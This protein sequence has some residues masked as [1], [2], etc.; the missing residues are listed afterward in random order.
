MEVQSGVQQP[1]PRPLASPQSGA[2]QQDELD[3]RQ[4]D[5]S[6]RSSTDNLSKDAQPATQNNDRNMSIMLLRQE[7]EPLSVNQP[8]RLL[9]ASEQRRD[10]GRINT[11]IYENIHL[12]TGLTAT[13]SSEW[14]ACHGFAV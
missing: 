13:G 12:M 8:E 11:Q 9:Y 2:N 10:S 7:P 3:D 5:A 14:D 6:G 1:E 4:T